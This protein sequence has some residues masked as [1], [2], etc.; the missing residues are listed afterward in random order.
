MIHCTHFGNHCFRAR[1]GRHVHLILYFRD[2]E[3]EALKMI[4]HTVEFF[5]KSGIGLNSQIRKNLSH[6]LMRHLVL[7]MR[8]K[9][10]EI[11]N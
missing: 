5:V 8:L 3:T 1:V 10:L 2:R 4:F 9:F 6:H 11:I 7:H